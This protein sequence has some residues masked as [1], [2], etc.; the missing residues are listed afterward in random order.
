VIEGVPRMSDVLR[1]S[2]LE[3]GTRGEND[4]CPIYN[5]CFSPHGRSWLVSCQIRP[6]AGAGD[7]F[8]RR[9][10]YRHRDDGF[11]TG[12]CFRALGRVTYARAPVGAGT[13]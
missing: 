9:D 7:V 13:A 1:F 8:R 11:R 6:A 4:R 10:S 12:S 2:S 3:R 5:C